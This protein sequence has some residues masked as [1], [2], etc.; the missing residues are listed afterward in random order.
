M[1]GANILCKNSR[2]EVSFFII[3]WMLLLQDT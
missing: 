3:M 1:E 2:T